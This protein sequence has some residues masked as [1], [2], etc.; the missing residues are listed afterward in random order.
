M[1]HLTHCEPI[2]QQPGVCLE[3]QMPGMPLK[4]ALQSPAKQQASQ[5]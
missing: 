2:G 3:Q 5:P 4:P 1:A